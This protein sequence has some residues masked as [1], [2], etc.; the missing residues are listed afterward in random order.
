MKLEIYKGKNCILTNNFDINCD[1]E[2]LQSIVI[3]KI[4]QSIER[5]LLSV[6]ELAKVIETCDEERFYRM[7][8]H[9]VEFQNIKE[10]K[11]N[12]IATYYNPNSDSIYE[13]GYIKNSIYVNE[14]YDNVGDI[15]CYQ[16]I[17]RINHSCL[18]GNGRKED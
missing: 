17:Y 8:N 4:I 14:Y 12:E 16:H 11:F 10:E 3:L 2:F 13:F 15:Y 18:F 9:Y 7:F 5:S 1:I 6:A